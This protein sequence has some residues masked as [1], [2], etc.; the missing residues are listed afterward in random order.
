MDEVYR[1]RKS[2]FV[3]RFDKTPRG[4]VC[5]HFYILGWAMGCPYRCAYCFLQGT[6]R[7][8]VRPQLFTNMGDLE[9]E[10]TGLLLGGKDPV[11]LNCGE[12]SDGMWGEKE[13]GFYETVLPL[14]NDP[15]INPYGHKLLILTKS[16]EIEGLLRFSMNNQIGDNIIVSWSVNAEEI[17]ERYE[18]GAPSPYV[19][20]EMAKSIRMAGYRVRL[21]ID[22]MIP[23]PEWADGYGKLVK[24]ILSDVRP[25]RITIGSLRVFPSVPAF[26]HK[27]GRDTEVFECVT[28]QD[29]PD[30]RYRLPL[31]TRLA[32]YRYI[33]DMIRG[34]CESGLCKETVKLHK[35]LMDLGYRPKQRCRCNCTP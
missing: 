23:Y 20:L 1:A 14:F 15:N 28:K 21:R 32:M 17:A 29:D 18:K 22:P 7:G 27:L 3:R 13:V 10:L 25:E 5:P 11:V 24:R 33:L 4:I 19:R 6:Y 8:Q 31:V 35:V 34:H 30:G 26:A 2:S 12:L 16:I 9:K